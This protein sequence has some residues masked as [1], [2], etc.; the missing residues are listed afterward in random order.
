[1][2]NYTHMSDR[3][4]ILDHLHGRVAWH[5]SALGNEGADASE[6]HGGAVELLQQAH[7]ALSAG[8]PVLRGERERAWLAGVIWALFEGL[9]EKAAR[10]EGLHQFQQTAWGNGASLPAP[11]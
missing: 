1:M 4:T 5:A 8:G 9:C 7:A 10:E 11:L 3:A 6:L 2:H